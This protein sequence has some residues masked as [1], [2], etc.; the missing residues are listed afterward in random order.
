MTYDPDKHA[1]RSIRL[2]DYDYAQPGAYFVTLCI[3]NRECLLGEVVEGIMH[4]NDVGQII[5]SVW[6][7]LPRHYPGVDIDAF[8]VMPNHV[9]GIIVLTAVGAAPRGRLDSKSAVGA[10]PR[11]R[12]NEPG[13]PQGVAPTMSLM[14][15]VHRFKSLTTAQYRHGT[16]R[17][18]WRPFLGRL[19][20]R[21][22]YEHII[23]NEE[24]LHCIRQYIADNPM[25]WETD[26]ENPYRQGND[27]QKIELDPNYST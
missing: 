9:H 15:V 19:W 6:D 8:V 12:P 24:E 16:I 25:R 2:R 26:R 10:T 27:R 23:R 21:N 22:Y 18:G 13:Q 7:E 14:D 1:R 4:V 11:G 5:Q 20:Q 3:Q 17:K